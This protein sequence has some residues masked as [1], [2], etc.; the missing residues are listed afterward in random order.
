MEHPHDPFHVRPFPQQPERGGKELN[1]ALDDLENALSETIPN[2][3][4]IREIQGRMHKAAG[5]FNDDQLI[6]RLRMLSKVLDSYEKSPSTE[7]LK[8]IITHL[9]KARIDLKK[10]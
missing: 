7:L 5:H 1:T 10:L 8:E 3:E 2:I 4:L 9:L 6:D